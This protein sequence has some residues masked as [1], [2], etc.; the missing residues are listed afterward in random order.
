LP[1]EYDRRHALSIVG[2]WKASAKVDVGFTLRASSGFPRTRPLGV[3]VVPV[4]DTL[5]ADKDGS[6]TELVPERDSAGLPVYTADYGSFKNLLRAR[7]PE[8]I[9]VDLRVN[10]RPRGDLSRW[11]FYLEFINAT[12]RKN[13]GQY[14]TT[15]R[16]VT[17]SDRPRVEENAAAS[18]PFLPTFGVRFR[19]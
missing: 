11:L 14:E 7:Y 15:L 17:G 2:Q 18:L 1:F 10:W 4:E 13:V 8:F 19:F 6:S 16:A 12:N 9:R 3:R 5:D